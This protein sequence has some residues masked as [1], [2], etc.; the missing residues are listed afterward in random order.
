MEILKINDLSFSYSTEKNGRQA[1]SHID[2]SIDEGQ[3]VLVCGPSGCGKS[4]LLK[5]IKPSLRPY[6]IRSGSIQLDEKDVDELS[7]RQ[8]SELIGFVMQDPE[9][10]IVTDKVFH[11]LSFG[12]ENLGM[13]NTQMH[14]RIAET[15]NYFGIQNII[16]KDTSEL[17][18]GQKQIVCLAGIMTM[19]PKI[20]LLDEPTSQLDPIA[21]S[22]FISAL[23][24]INEELGTTII[25]TEHRYESLFPVVDR[26]VFMEDGCIISDSKPQKSVAKLINKPEYIEVLPTTL[27]VYEATSDLTGEAPLTVREGREYLRLL[28]KMKDKLPVLNSQ[29]TVNYMQKNLIPILSAKEV[30]FKYDTSGKDVL[31]KFNFDVF[32]GELMCIIGANGSGK[33]T[34]IMTASGLFTPYRGKVCF[35]GKNIRTY[36]KS[37]FYGKQVA[38][39]VQ[40]PICTFV[41][42]TIIEE[43]ACVCKNFSIPK[44]RLNEVIEL[45]ELDNILEKH[46][47]D[48]SGG[49][50]QRA[51]I[52]ALLLPNPEVIFLD[53]ATKGMDGF[54]KKKF[55]IFLKR[56]TAGGTAVV[57]VSHDIEFCAEYADRCAMFFDGTITAQGTPEQILLNN[58]FYT[59]TANRLSRGISPAVLTAD[60]LIDSVK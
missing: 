10:Q 46:P 33:T 27:R 35:K 20:L 14:I 30:Y 55:G 53:E 11:E 43:L 6:G 44:Q 5:Q 23:K 56:V 52:A 54:F 3:F 38:L 9:M 1:L 49:E 41:H 26:V 40:N 2:L 37:A 48:I 7:F 59:T 47:Y 50:I 58:S 36:K 17:S 28:L 25:I 21:A 19:Q 42:D 32:S 34:A 57:L 12:L 8:Q 15:V 4:T 18:G 16:N 51:A 31:R 60:E 45:M 22:D 24:R 39:L 13:S 29:K